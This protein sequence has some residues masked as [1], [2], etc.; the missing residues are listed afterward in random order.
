METVSCNLCGSIYQEPLWEGKDWAYGSPG[1]FTMVRC[2]ECGLIFLNPRPTLSEIGS[3]YPR[4]YEPYQQD[5]SAMHSRWLALIRRAKL[6]PRVRLILRLAQGGYL[7][8][9]GCASGGFIHELRQFESWHVQGV[10]SNAE[11]A[12]F[13]RQQLGLDVF[14]GQLEDARFPSSFFDVVTMWDVLEHIHDPLTTVKEVCRI[15]KPGGI[16]VCSTPNAN[17]LDAKIFGRYWVGLDFPRH[18]YLFSPST[19]A[20]LFLKTGLKLERSFCFYGR[21]TTFALSILLWLNA[22]VHYQRKQRA[23]LRSIL[24]FPLFRYVT[25]PYFLLLDIFQRGAIITALAR[26]TVQNA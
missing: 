9:V 7:L 19:L 6:W 10:E 14:C 16:F 5:I 26:K 8:D 11:V 4:D 25:L 1:E 24:L 2:T 21:Y 3:Y 18:L 23:L 13:A 20:I 12:C 17:S 22:H 15:L